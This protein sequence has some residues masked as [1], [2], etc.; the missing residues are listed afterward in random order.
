MPTTMIDKKQL[1]L[2]WGQSSF[3]FV[4]SDK[5][6][7]Q[8]FLNIPFNAALPGGMGPD[9][10]EGIRLTAVIQKAVMDLKTANKKINLSLPIRDIIFRSF[11]IPAM[12]PHEVKS[13]VEFEA[14]KY[15]PIKLDELSFTYHPVPIIEN[16]Q[17]KIRIIF[18][19]IRK[20]ILERYTGILEHSGFQVLGIEPAPVSTVRVLQR[21]KH[22]SRQQTSAII[23]I[24]KDQGRI[25]IV[26]FDVVQFIREF[27]LPNEPADSMAFGITLFNDVRV[28]FN[29]YSRQNPPGKIE[30]IVILSMSGLGD[31][32]K[33]LA[34]EVSIPTSAISIDKIFN[35]PAAS[36]MELVTA[37]GASLKEKM[38]VS[39]DFDLSERATKLLRT[40][41][42]PGGQPSNY[43]TITL[44]LF[45]AVI[46]TAGSYFL[47]SSSING[48]QKKI[49]ELQIKQGSFQSSSIEQ[50]NE[51]TKA[52]SD[53]LTAYQNIRLKSDIAFYL[54]RIPSL[55]PAGIWMRGLELR[56]TTIE[57]DKA[58]LMLVM[59]GYAFHEIPNEE[60]RLAQNF[61]SRLKE[62]EDFKKAFG[63]IDLVTVQQERFN[64]YTVAG[65][66]INC[67]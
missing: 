12:E 43:K 20:A 39:K 24:G 16:N 55:L 59:D 8:S 40:S 21:Q 41:S 15:I 53:K 5:G 28:S 35:N 44:S 27:P 30:K 49:T 54:K 26:E 22:L 23:E 42:A 34:A 32:A 18:V 17:K 25:I 37:Y 50:I 58:K 14:T 1:G 66:R 60:F 36:H 48:L 51:L 33:N 4:E 47:S 29:F 3:S 63:Q 62:T 46:L 2:Y 13:V 31:L 11:I 6:P 7:A 64:N 67:Q 52:K 19:A 9:V 38:V 61:V 57:Q 65:F 10:P 56:Y 45:A